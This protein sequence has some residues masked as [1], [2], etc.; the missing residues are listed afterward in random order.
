MDLSTKTEIL[1]YINEAIGCNE[2]EIEIKT[3]KEGGILKEIEVRIKKNTDTLQYLVKEG[4]MSKRQSEFM[5]REIKEGSS[6]I[7]VGDSGHDKTRLTRAL[8]NT[9][10]NRNITIYQRDFEFKENEFS[11]NNTSIKIRQDVEVNDVIKQR[12]NQITVLNDVDTSSYRSA[13]AILLLFETQTLATLPKYEEG[14]GWLIKHFMGDK[15]ITVDIT[16]DEYEGK[17]LIITRNDG[18]YPWEEKDRTRIE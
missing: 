13:L 11:N 14:L 15:L 3:I 9:I 17:R 12:E 1:D 7:I 10:R 16:T 6:I 2:T 8:L 5:E 18:F 4:L